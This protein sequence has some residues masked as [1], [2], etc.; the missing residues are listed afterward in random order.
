ML[1]QSG[2]AFLDLMA[3]SIFAP[4]LPYI[5]S[6]IGQIIAPWVP[7]APF[8]KMRAI[9]AAMS[10]QSKQVFYSKRAALEK[11]DQAVVH[12]VGEG[13]DILSILSASHCLRRTSYIVYLFFSTVK[14]NMAANED[15]KLPEAELIAQIRSGVFMQPAAHY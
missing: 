10:E 7:S 2:P 5:P 13:K 4:M 12:Q 3:W 11:G 8:Q 15:D 14:E 1:T 6:A 9:R